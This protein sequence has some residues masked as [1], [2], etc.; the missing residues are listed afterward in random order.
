M[1]WWDFIIRAAVFA[2]LAPLWWRVVRLADDGELKGVDYAHRRLVRALSNAI[3]GSI[4]IAALLV[5]APLL[6]GIVRDPDIVIG[7]F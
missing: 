1:G 2:I 3:V 4:I 7:L 6:R 5:I